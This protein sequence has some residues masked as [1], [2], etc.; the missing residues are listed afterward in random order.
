MLSS[1]K[2]QTQPNNLKDSSV[3]E[4]KPH[5]ENTNQ[6]IENYDKARNELFNSKQISG[7]IIGTAMLTLSTLAI[8][9]IAKLPSSALNHCLLQYSKWLLPSIIG[10]T[11]LSFYIGDKAT[12]TRITK[13]Q[14]NYSTT[15][16][17]HQRRPENTAAM[18]A[19]NAIKHLIMLLYTIAT[20]IITYLLK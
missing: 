18:K 5:Q 11:L 6:N 16:Q 9:F 2:T 8:G 14:K 15:L 1:Y 10:L 19:I 20:F 7:Q 13:L 4:I 12:D 3:D 17:K